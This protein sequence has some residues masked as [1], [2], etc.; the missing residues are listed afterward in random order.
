MA[1]SKRWSA[2]WQHSF[3]DLIDVEVGCSVL[4]VSCPAGRR[5]WLQAD[6]DGASMNPRLAHAPPSPTALRVS[7][8][9]ASGRGVSG[10]VSARSKNIFRDEGWIDVSGAHRTT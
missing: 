9:P 3:V 1:L 10:L 6:E 5:R 2:G 4:E 7:T 8:S